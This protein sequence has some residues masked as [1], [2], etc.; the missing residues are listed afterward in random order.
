MGS[1]ELPASSRDACTAGVSP[2]LAWFA[3][4]FRPIMLEQTHASTYAARLLL[5]LQQSA[6]AEALSWPSS[7]HEKC[8]ATNQTFMLLSPAD[9]PEEHRQAFLGQLEHMQVRDR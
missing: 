1:L 8:H 4:G 7:A 3:G 5:L 9:L 6:A 2:Q